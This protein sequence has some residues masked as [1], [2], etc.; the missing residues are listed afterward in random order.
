MTPFASSSMSVTDITT[1]VGTTTGSIYRYL[2]GLLP[3]LLIFGVII[4]ALFF[5]IRWI[6]S[7]FRGHGTSAR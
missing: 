3:T 1:L 7:A 2:N 5:A 6:M 4:G